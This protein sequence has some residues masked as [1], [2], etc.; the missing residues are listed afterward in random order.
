MLVTYQR[1][2]NLLLFKLVNV[3][4]KVD[5]VKMLIYLSWVL[6]QKPPG[7]KFCYE[8]RVSF[9]LVYTVFASVCF[10]ELVSS[11]LLVTV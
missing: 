3:G 7:Y 6:K 4:V 8:K 11:S 2:A 1:R 9:L 5:P 10:R